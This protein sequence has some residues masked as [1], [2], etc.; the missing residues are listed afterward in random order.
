MKASQERAG[1]CICSEDGSR[2]ALAII[3]G[4]KGDKRDVSIGPLGEVYGSRHQARNKYYIKWE[5]FFGRVRPPQ[6]IAEFIGGN[7]F[8]KSSSRYFSQRLFCS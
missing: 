1:V 8:M 4:S 6:V 5:T 7:I 3:A 2:V